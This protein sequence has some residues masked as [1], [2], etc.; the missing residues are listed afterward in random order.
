MNER[1]EVEV[2]SDTQF[3]SLSCLYHEC[4]NKVPHKHKLL[5]IEF[6]SKHALVVGSLISM[7]VYGKPTQMFWLEMLKV[8]N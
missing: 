6:R 5:L 3:L 2:F 4:K 8:Q 1:K 7:K